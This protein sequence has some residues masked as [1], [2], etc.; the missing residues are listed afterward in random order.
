MKPIEALSIVAAAVAATAT[1][2]G[3]WSS[4]PINEQNC[5]ATDW[6]IW[7][8]KIR[9]LID[10]HDG[11]LD[12]L[13]GKIVKPYPLPEG[14]STEDEKKHKEKSDFF[15]KANSYAKSMITTAVTDSAYQKIMD[16]ETAHDT[17]EALK[18][19]FEATPMD[20]VFRICNEFFAFSWNPEKKGKPG[21]FFYHSTKGA[22]SGFRS[23]WSEILYHSQLQE[24]G[25]LDQELQK[26]KKDGHPKPSYQN[27]EQGNC[28][29]PTLTLVSVHNSVFAS[30]ANSEVDWWI[31]NGA[32]KHVVKT[33]KYFEHFEK[34]E[35]PSWIR[36]DGNE[37][38]PAL[39]QGT[40]KVKTIVNVLAA[41]DNN[42]SSRFESS[43]TKC[44]LKI[45][46]KIVLV[47]A[48][49][50]GG[51][52]YRAAIEPILPERNVDVNVATSGTS[53]IQLY[54]ERWGHQDKNHIKDMLKRD[55]HSSQA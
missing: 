30:E 10:Y 40:I 19:Q 51:T 27:A 15:R 14:A 37:T 25:T 8:G 42:P 55:M 45:N 46:D 53:I 54:H 20:K 34:F 18:N 12:A 39:G 7:K 33:V 43:A 35:N 41:Q 23:I 44:T 4:T 36:A 24:K 29:E 31:D 21:G 50:I 13:D 28:A 5:G 32:T 6:P 2:A 48:R 22:S 17:W 16:K 38:L 47:G 3:G 11:A 1:E 49:E 9:D 26:W 52:L